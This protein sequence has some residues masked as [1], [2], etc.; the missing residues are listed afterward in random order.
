MERGTS[1]PDVIQEELADA[2]ADQGVDPATI[3]A[4]DF[5]K[6]SRHTLAGGVIRLQRQHLIEG[7]GH[8]ARFTLDAL[9]EAHFRKAWQYFMP[10]LSSLQDVG[11]RYVQSTYS[12]GRDAEHSW[13]PLLRHRYKELGKL[14]L[15]IHRKGRRPT[16]DSRNVLL[17]ALS[18]SKG[19]RLP[20]V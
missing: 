9:D 20:R 15:D 13:F 5:N 1:G 10:E 6:L 19:D 2:I 16:L 18:L 12:A 11:A 7:E 4:P 3:S 14:G 17:I 8:E